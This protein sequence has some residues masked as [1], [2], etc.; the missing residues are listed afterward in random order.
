VQE[1]QQNLF[2]QGRTMK[3]WLAPALLVF[4]VIAV[5]LF[6]CAHSLDPTQGAFLSV[7]SSL[8]SGCRKCVAV[9]NADAI[10]IISNKAVIDPTKCIKCYKCVDACPYDA[11][12]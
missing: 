6:A 10:T 3:K 12:Y 4:A 2:L 9:C 11:I 8:C 1:L 7:D 5:A